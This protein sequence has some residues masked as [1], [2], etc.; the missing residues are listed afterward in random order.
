M[1]KILLSTL[2]FFNLSAY[3]AFVTPNELADSMSSNNKLI[4]LDVS[5]REIYKL[6]HIKHA[7]HVDTKKIYS[8]ELQDELRELGI[9]TDSTVV[10][11]SRNTKNSILN[12][13][14]LAFTLIR[15]G[16]ENVS[17]LDG[18]YMAWVFEHM[19]KT[20]SKQFYAP[21]R[22]NITLNDSNLTVG[23]EFMQKSLL[24]IK[25]LDARTANEY[26]GL[27]KS[28]N[29]QALGHI[30]TAQSSYYENKFLSDNRLRDTGEI[31]E[32]Y[33]KGYELKKDKTTVVYANTML[34]ASMEWFILYKYLNL[35]NTK[36]YEGSFIEW[37]N[38]S[39]LT[40]TRFKW[41]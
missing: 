10:I 35:K 26:Y 24:N 8:K 27:I 32:I 16:F 3:S 36:I 9:N 14:Y 13:S 19:L 23:K 2:L 34:E 17:L 22:G 6:S 31:E 37:G 12:S 39:N 21:Q 41:E 29:I 38:D 18:G 1:K 25:I 15:N 40:T 28:Q 5:Q 33:I 7:I 11:Y 30:P 4:I 20:S